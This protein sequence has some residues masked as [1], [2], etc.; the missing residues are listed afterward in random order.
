LIVLI[1]GS[2]DDSA[3][4][5]H[6]LQRLLPAEGVGVFVYDKRGTGFSGGTYTQDFDL[7]AGDAVVA[8]RYAQDY[9][10]MMRDFA[11]DGRLHGAYGKSTIT[12]GTTKSP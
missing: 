4:R 12:R 8:M 11:R 10:A 2:E 9:F 6:Q 1:H 7:L 3:I 5:F